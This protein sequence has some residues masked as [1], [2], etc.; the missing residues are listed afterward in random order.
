MDLMIFR[1][2]NQNSLRPM[3]KRE[4]E[5][6]E[7]QQQQFTTTATREKNEYC[8]RT[9]EKNVPVDLRAVCLVRAIVF[10]V[11]DFCEGTNEAKKFE[12]EEIFLN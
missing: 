11:S 8:I 6:E 3:I 1:N 9:K 12:K 7:E 5:E 2:H 10:Q 4:N